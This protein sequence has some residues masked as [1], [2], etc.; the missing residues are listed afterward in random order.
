MTCCYLYRERMKFEIPAGQ[1]AS[2]GTPDIPAGTPKTDD[3]GEHHVFH[4]D[5]TVQLPVQRGSKGAFTLPLKVGYQGCNEPV[6]LCYPPQTKEFQLQMPEATAVSA[7][8]G[9]AS[10]VGG[11]V[12]KQ[13]RLANL[14]RTGNIFVMA[15][16]FFLGGTAARIHPLRTA[17]GAHRGRHHC[18]RRY[19]RDPWPGVLAVRGLCLGMAATYTVAGVAFAAAGQQAQTLFQQPWIILLFSGLFVAMAMSMFGF[20]TVQMPSF[21]Q[22]RLTQMSNEQKAGSYAGVASW[23]RFRH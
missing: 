20:Y 6:G 22:T 5:V 18:R 9:G 14:I 16:A 3:L 11:Y 12:S 10:S 19:Q 7:L 1:P 13:D 23:A 4:E 17:D 2:L 8:S 21:I 15:G